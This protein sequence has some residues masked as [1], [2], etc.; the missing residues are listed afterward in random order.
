VHA[1]NQTASHLAPWTTISLS[2]RRYRVLGGKAQLS[3]FLIP[4]LK[5]PG[6]CPL[7]PPVLLAGDHARTSLNA[8]VVQ[9][10]YNRTNPDAERQKYL[11]PI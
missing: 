9:S 8:G 1:G 4:H 11:S 6:T 10:Q 5:R 7:K 3:A 2:F